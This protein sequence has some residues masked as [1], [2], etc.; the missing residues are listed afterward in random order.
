MVAWRVLVGLGNRIMTSM[1]PVLYSDFVYQ[2]LELG[3]ILT[4]KILGSYVVA[5]PKH[6]LWDAGISITGS[7]ADRGI[8]LVCA[9][10]NLFEENPRPGARDT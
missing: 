4:S 1:G 6:H 9:G 8:F 7:A 3:V 10:L 5:P 2:G